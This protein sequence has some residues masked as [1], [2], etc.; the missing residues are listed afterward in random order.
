MYAIQKPYS[1]VQN[2]TTPGH[3]SSKQLQSL[4]AI[5]CLTCTF[6]SVLA[7]KN[8]RNRYVLSF[9]YHNMFFPQLNFK[10]LHSAI[11]MS[12]LYH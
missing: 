2:Y 4:D 10:K 8:K 5:S 6:L 7:G 12:F 11:S 9:L 1:N 3:L